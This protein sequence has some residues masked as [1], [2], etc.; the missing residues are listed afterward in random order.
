MLLD[1]AEAYFAS[2]NLGATIAL[3]VMPAAPDYVLALTEYE[4]APDDLGFGFDG[5]AFEYPGLRIL[6]RGAPKDKQTP[7]LLIE[8]AKQAA[9]R[10][11]AMTLTGTYGACE[12]LIWRPGTVYKLSVDPSDRQTYGVNVFVQKRPSPLPVTSP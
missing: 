1:E 10:V 5:A 7:R 4:V 9:A 12:H 8:R 11:Q 2:L 3:D 6:A